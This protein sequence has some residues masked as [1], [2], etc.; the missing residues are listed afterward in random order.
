MIHTSP[1]R[2]SEEVWSAECTAP[3]ATG[4]ESAE[5]LTVSRCRNGKLSRYMA[6]NGF[7]HPCRP[8]QTRASAAFCRVRSASGNESVWWE[9]FPHW[10]ALPTG[11]KAAAL[12]GPDAQAC[13]SSTKRLHVNDEN[14]KK[15]GCEPPATAV[16]PQR[17]HSPPSPRFNHYPKPWAAPSATCTPSKPR[18]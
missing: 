2:R 11:G 9:A 12:H 8:L 5:D 15:K 13:R 1:D 6:A 7:H 18:R 16:S 3:C 14:E 10:A 17:Q 4:A